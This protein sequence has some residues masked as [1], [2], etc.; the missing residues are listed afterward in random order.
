MIALVEAVRAGLFD[1]RHWAAN[2][3]AGVVVG[4][5]SLPLSMA[6]AIASG[7]RPVDGLVSGVVAGLVVAI[8]GG[9]RTQIAGPTGAFIAILAGISATHGRDGLLIAGLLAGVLLI[10]FALLRLGR[11]IGHV[12]QAVVTGFT[13]GIGVVIFLGQ[14]PGF[15]G[16]AAPPPAALPVRLAALLG[17]LPAADPATTGLALL[18]LMLMLKGPHLPGLARVPGPLLAMLVTTLLHAG[19]GLHGV[20]TIG[21]VYGAIRADW[22]APAWP[23]GLSERWLALLPAALSIALLGALESLLSARI[24]DP[25]H[26][27]DQELRAQGFANLLVPLFGGLAVSGAIGRTAASLRLGA[28]SPLAGIVHAL[29]LLAI[30]LALAPLAARVPI[31]ALAAILVGVSGHLIGWPA[32][33]EAWKTAPRSEW[34]ALLVTATLTLTVNLVVA[35]AVGVAVALLGRRLSRRAAG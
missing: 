25:D 35:V 7:M 11:L 14:V 15:F 2:L 27:A 32:L 3:S 9:T 26:D 5:V 31:C 29:T 1:R 18:A 20:A 4:I 16:I 34:I 21:D 6:F 17:S 28:T 22:P 24:A 23:S 30:L 8:F 33:V 12:P 10:A 19:L 13:A